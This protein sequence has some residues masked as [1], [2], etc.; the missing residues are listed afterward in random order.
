[1]CDGSFSNFAPISQFNFT[2]ANKRN[3]IVITTDR[4]LM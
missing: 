1:M 4:K 3:L 2:K